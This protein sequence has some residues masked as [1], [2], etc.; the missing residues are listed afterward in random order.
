[1][2]TKLWLASLVGVALAVS[3]AS[4]GGTPLMY[5]VVDCVDKTECKGKIATIRIWGSFSR[6]EPPMSRK[7]TTPVY[8]FIQF[9]NGSDREAPKWEKAAKTGKAVVVGCCGG[10]GAFE[11]TRIYKASE[12]T[13]G[14]DG[15]YPTGHLELYG[16]LYGTGSRDDELEAKNLVAFAKAL[17]IDEDAMDRFITDSIVAGLKED[18]VPR[19]LAGKLAKNPDFLG[20]CTLCRPT[21]RGFVK[22][23]EL[24]KQPNGKGLPE[25]LQTRLS[26]KDVPTRHAAL[27]ELVQK[28]VERGYAGKSLN[29]EQQ[30]EMRQ[31]IVKHRPN[32][33]IQLPNGQTFCPSC[34]GTACVLKR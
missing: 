16:D 28:Y 13:I 2:I 30:K 18:G 31:M 33:E 7:F 26:S 23:S 22:Y 24:D 9:G 32:R 19:E 17:K 25:E 34:D 4:A 10:A 15:P 12:K 11:T 14:P 21:Q 1:M 27:R 6:Q 20:K 5:V 3:S 8:G 29:D